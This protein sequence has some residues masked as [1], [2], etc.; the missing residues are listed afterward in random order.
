MRICIFFIIT[1]LLQSCNLNT[2]EQSKTGNT[3]GDTLYIQYAAGFNIIRFKNYTEAIIYNPWDKG[4]VQQ[5]YILIDRNKEIPAGI[6]EGTVVKVPI[7]S[8]ACYSAIQVS[9]F[10]KL[11]SI[12]VINAVA[13]PGYIANPAIHEGINSGKITDLGPAV[14]V[15]VEK[16]IASNPEIIIAVHFR[17][18]GYGAVEKTGIPIVECIDYME[19]SPLG[20]TE[21]IKFIAEFIGKQ[22][23]AEILFD[24]ISERYNMLC[25]KTSGITKRPTIFSEKKYGNSWYIA[26]GQSVAAIGFGH[27]GTEYLWNDLAGTGSVP[28]SFESVYARAENADYWMFKYNLPDEKALTYDAL[29]SEYKPY[30]HFK[31]FKERKILAC[32]TGLKPYYETGLLEPDVVLADL[33]HAIHPDILPDHEPVYIDFLKE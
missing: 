33:I 20:Q 4:R 25:E 15:A 24:E 1:C 23:E 2:A 9:I 7:Q 29:K 3:A 16:L 13:E 5:K 10:D 30:E 32:N 28:M 21:W 18:A 19:L 6:P 11:N 8:A 17:N 14:S 26:C 27:A 12:G 31:A 22:D